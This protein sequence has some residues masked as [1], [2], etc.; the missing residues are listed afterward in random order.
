MITVHKLRSVC[1]ED[2]DVD[3]E[4]GFKQRTGA[5]IPDQEPVSDAQLFYVVRHSITVL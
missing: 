3:I 1:K 5:F 2:R 4:C